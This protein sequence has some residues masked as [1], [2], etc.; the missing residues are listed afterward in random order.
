MKN[1]KIKI[2]KS[3]LKGIHASLTEDKKRHSLEDK[4][5]EK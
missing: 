1:K 3:E 5:N 2:L 4:K